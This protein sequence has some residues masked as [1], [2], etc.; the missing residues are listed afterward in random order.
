MKIWT[1]ILFLVIKLWINFKCL[2]SCL[3]SLVLILFSWS[4]YIEQV[5]RLR[6]VE[7]TGEIHLTIFQ[8]GT[9]IGLTGN[10]QTL[11]QGYPVAFYLFSS[12]TNPQ[13]ASKANCN[14]PQGIKQLYPSQIWASHSS[15]PSPHFPGSPCTQ[16]W[17]YH[18]ILANWT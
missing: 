13:I 18:L 17:P 14:K 12:L 3:L 2:Y 8:I 6:Y 10:L 1:Q 9:I 7:T 5:S 16:R 11:V 4:F 15:L